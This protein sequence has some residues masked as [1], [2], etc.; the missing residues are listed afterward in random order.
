MKKIS[1]LL[2]LLSVACG[3]S[4][5]DNDRTLA[6]PSDL[7]IEAGSDHLS[8][9]LFW[10]D[11]APN[12]SGYYVFIVEGTGTAGEPT[13][14]LPAGSTSYSFD[15]LAYDMS[16]RFGVQAF[17][18]DYAMSRQVWYPELFMTPTTEPVD[19]QP[20]DPNPIEAIRFHWTEV[21]DLGL[22]AEVKVYKTEDPLNGRAFNAW[23]A[24]ADPTEVDVRVL[25]PGK[26]VT[27]TLDA[28]AEAAENCLVLINGGIFGST[29]EPIGFA[30]ADGT[31]TPW[32][33][34]PGDGYTE[35]PDKQAWGAV[36]NSAY[37]RLHPVSRGM[38]GVD[39]SGTPGVYWS[40]TPEYGS[41]YVYDEPLPTVAGGAV[42]PEGSATYPCDAAEWTPYN[43]LTCGPVLLKDG[44][45]PINNKKTTQGYWET[46]YELWA[47]DIYGVDQRADRTAI[48]YTADGKVILLVCDGRIT[49]SQGATTLE[50][51]AIMKGLG[52]TGALNLDGGGSTGMWAGGHHL[53]DLT[54]G[55]RPLV[56]T[57]GFFSK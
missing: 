27:R 4:K 53:N 48:G 9:T 54:G 57:V 43:A 24:V 47:D 45:C 21:S 51:A 38:F 8:G 15:G 23:Y 44:R 13:A 56:V 19:P 52:C 34:V 12:E 25:F 5:D 29:G 11:N 50:M 33:E 30:I 32:R 7:R 37:N 55:N 1:F 14:T 6:D 26:G 20:E 22:P 28:Q 42:H 36:P 16:Y 41:V 35:Y 49:A 40:Y 3:S 31:Q 2:L 39:H 46:N 17:G 10:T 18:K